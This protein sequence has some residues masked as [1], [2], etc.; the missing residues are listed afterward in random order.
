MLRNIIQLS[1]LIIGLLSASGAW[2]TTY[3]IDYV[4]GSDSNNGTSKST[5]WKLAPGMYGCWR[6]GSAPGRPSSATACSSRAAS[7]LLPGDRVIFKGG[8]TWPKGCFNWHYYSGNGTTANPIYFGV[9]QTWYSGSSWTRPIFDQQGTEPTPSY[10][11]YKG[12]VML[13][14]DGL[15]IDNIEFKGL[16]QLSDNFSSQPGMLGIGT[17]SSLS[18]QGLE[19]KNCY[20]HGWSHGGTATKDLMFILSSTA[21]TSPEMNLKIHHNVFDGSDTTKDMTG[22]I[23]GSVGHFYNNYVADVANMLIATN[24]GY[25]WGNTFVNIAIPRGINCTAQNGVASYF[26]FDCTTHGN[27]DETYGIH[28]AYYNN[29]SLNVGG[30]ANLI[31]YP[32]PSGSTS[33]FNNVIVNDGNQ[34]MQLGAQYMTS[35]NTFGYN[36]FNNTIQ[37]TNTNGTINGGFAGS[38]YKFS[39][40]NIRNNHIISPRSGSSIN[41]SLY[42]TTLTQDHNLDQTLAQATSANYLSSTNYSPPPGGATVGAGYNMSTICSQIPVSSPSDPVTACLSD[43]TMGVA[44]DATNHVV[45]GPNITPALRGAT[46]DVGAYQFLA[47][48]LAPPG[49]PYI[50]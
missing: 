16:A 22:I 24:T 11:G 27:T 12:M 30:G 37:A 4:G 26:S 25:I 38:S 2:A 31:Y 44:Y 48:Q 10:Y 6:E 19:I 5:P 42:T 29:Y 41:M 23:K 45:T 1:I 15:I 43:T 40:A 46:W 47:S 18:T 34:T 14:G 9:D 17:G 21:W 32:S 8:V 49:K 50:P 36:I 28:Y 35:G 13:Q 39:Y 20:F 7:G 3:Y 33:I